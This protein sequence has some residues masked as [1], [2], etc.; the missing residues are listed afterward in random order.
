MGSVL[1]T[2]DSPKV[3]KPRLPRPVGDVVVDNS[4]FFTGDAVV[5]DDQV[6]SF[7]AITFFIVVASDVVFGD[8][9]TS[10]SIVKNNL[11]G[12]RW[13]LSYCAGEG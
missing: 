13:F 4:S 1:S 12:T 10:F 9:M 5:F 6:T 2:F 7:S 3:A 11:R 8:Q